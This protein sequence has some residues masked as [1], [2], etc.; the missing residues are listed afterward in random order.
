[1]SDCVNPTAFSP[2]LEI[3]ATPCHF[4]GVIPRH[5]SSANVGPHR[6]DRACRGDAY[7]S[8]K[9]RTAITAASHASQVGIDIGTG[10][11]VEIGVAFQ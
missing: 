6:V 11:S 2:I 4:A 10:N 5:T 7:I 1:M 9:R 8:H 3:K